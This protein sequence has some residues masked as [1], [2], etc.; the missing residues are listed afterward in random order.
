[1]P[2]KRLSMRKIKEVLRLRF[3]LGLQQDQTSGGELL[4]RRCPLRSRNDKAFNARYPPVVQALAAMPDETVIDGEI[5]ANGQPSLW[6][7]GN[8]R[9]SAM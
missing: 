7:F 2:Q 5:V 6:P 3:G 1:L 8:S 9:M 4:P